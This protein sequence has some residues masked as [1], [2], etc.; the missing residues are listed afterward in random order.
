MSSDSFVALLFQSGQLGRDVSNAWRHVDTTFKNS[1]QGFHEVSNREASH[2]IS[3]NA[4]FKC[5]ENV[6]L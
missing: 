4:R 3:M 2:D 6:T 5:L 1:A